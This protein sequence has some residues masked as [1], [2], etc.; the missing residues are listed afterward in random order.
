LNT[1]HITI[2]G[3]FCFYTTQSTYAVG[4][5]TINR[6]DSTGVGEPE[7][8]NFYLSGGLVPESGY[9]GYNGYNHEKWLKNAEKGAKNGQKDAKTGLLRR[10][11][12]KW[13]NRLRLQ[14]GYKM[15]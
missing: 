2:Y 13:C 5:G 4:H 3:G 14:S 15:D 6:R 8:N 12:V 1:N 11:L 10:I 7:K 9:N